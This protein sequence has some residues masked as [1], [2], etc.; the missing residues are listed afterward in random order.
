MYCTAQVQVSHCD[1]STYIST[2]EKES[3]EEGFRGSC[4]LRLLLPNGGDDA[5]LNIVAANFL[6]AGEACGVIFI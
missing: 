6:S 5:E 2:F 3:R 1:I 4:S